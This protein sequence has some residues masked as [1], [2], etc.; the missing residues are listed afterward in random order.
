MKK[1]FVS[2]KVKVLHIST[3]DI[4]CTSGGQQ[5]GLNTG[6]P[7]IIPGTEVDKPVQIW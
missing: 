1:A 4:I 2:P 6:D 3:Q 7:I 5:G